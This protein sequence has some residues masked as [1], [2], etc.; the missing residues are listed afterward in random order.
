MTWNVEIEQNLEKDLESVVGIHGLNYH[1]PLFPC[2]KL[3]RAKLIYALAQDLSGKINNDQ[4]LFASFIEITHAYTLIHDDLPCMDNDDFRRGKPSTHKKFGEAQALLIGDGLQT[5]AY[6]LLARMSSHNLSKLLKIVT[7]CLG[8]KGIVGGQIADM[9]VQSKISFAEILR[10]HELKTSR[11]MQ[12]ALL[13]S[14]ILSD[15]P[16]PLF[17]TLFKLGSELG[18]L[19][20][21]LDDR[22]EKSTEKENFKNTFVRFPEKNLQSS[23]KLFSSLQASLQKNTLF[24]TLKLC[25]S[26]FPSTL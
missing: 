9:E 21:L 18:I 11:L 19:F 23:Q 6:N 25:N 7:W 5:G 17:K 3:F 4:K 2:G 12:A 13:G 20:Q 8:P 16:K 24:E 1:Y 26:F 14:F 22:Q 15:S 10:I